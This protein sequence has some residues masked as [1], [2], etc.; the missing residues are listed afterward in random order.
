MISGH[1][2]GLNPLEP[3]QLSVQPD[4]LKEKKPASFL[5]PFM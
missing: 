4:I 3:A 2:Q 5:Q 1:L